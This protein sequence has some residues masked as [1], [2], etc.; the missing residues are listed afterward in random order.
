[1]KKLHPRAVWLFFFSR[2]I[3]WIFIAD[4][5]AIQGSFILIVFKLNN[6]IPSQI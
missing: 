1:M 2:I 6:K 4:F 5:I 3:A